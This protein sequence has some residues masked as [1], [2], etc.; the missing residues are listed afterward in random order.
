[1]I[2]GVKE[3]V[4]TEEEQKRRRDLHCLGVEGGVSNLSLRDLQGDLYDWESTHTPVTD[5]SNYLGTI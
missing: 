4:F 1:M 3:V 2:S 5:T